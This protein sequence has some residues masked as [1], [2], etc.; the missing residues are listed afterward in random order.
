MHNRKCN[1]CG[2]PATIVQ[3]NY[4]GSLYLE[5]LPSGAT[6]REIW[7]TMRHVNTATYW[8]E[9]CAREEQ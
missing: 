3:L 6:G 5:L 1:R 8:C 7:Q 2:R 9:P 4:T